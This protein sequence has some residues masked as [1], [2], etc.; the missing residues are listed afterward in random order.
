M[1]GL[2]LSVAIPLWLESMV[3]SDETGAKCRRSRRLRL[4]ETVAAT[5]ESRAKVKVETTAVLVRAVECGAK[6]DATNANDAV[7]SKEKIAKAAIANAAS[8]LKPFHMV[9]SCS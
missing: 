1:L 6:V 7:T 5:S 3:S 9:F 4:E 2:N 8:A